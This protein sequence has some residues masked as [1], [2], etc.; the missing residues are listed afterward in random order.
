[1]HDVGE[2]LRSGRLTFGL[3]YKPMGTFAGVKEGA[4]DGF[5]VLKV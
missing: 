5:E 1:M 4:R 3:R 2:V